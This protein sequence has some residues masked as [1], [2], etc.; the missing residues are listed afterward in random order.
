MFD[1][2]DNNQDG[3]IAVDELKLMLKKLR[4]DL[5]DEIVEDLVRN[6]SHTGKTEQF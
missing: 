5:R 4:I 2:V 6:G 1:L 3:K